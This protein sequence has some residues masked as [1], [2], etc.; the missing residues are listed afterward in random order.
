MIAEYVGMDVH[1]SFIR[2]QHLTFLAPH[3]LR[4]F[5]T[6]DASAGPCVP[7]PQFHTIPSSYSSV[8]KHYPSVSV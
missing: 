2:T 4:E 7:H 1:H 8:D 3:F 5:V 6:T